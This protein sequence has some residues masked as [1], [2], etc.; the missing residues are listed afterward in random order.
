M[1]R[2][3]CPN[4]VPSSQAL[5]LHLTSPCRGSEDDQAEAGQRLKGAQVMVYLPPSRQGEWGTLRRTVPLQVGTA[6]APRRMLCPSGLLREEKGQRIEKTVEMVLRPYSEATLK[7][8][9]LVTQLY[10]TL[11]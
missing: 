3:L 4:S 1:E 2:P 10:P 5:S 9:V 8:R 11:F 7:V 6:S